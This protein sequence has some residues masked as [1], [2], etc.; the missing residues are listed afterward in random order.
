M[1]RRQLDRL[2]PSGGPTHDTGCIGL[3]FRYKIHVPRRS[4]IGPRVENGYTVRK[5]HDNRKRIVHAAN[6]PLDCEQLRSKAHDPD[7]VPQQ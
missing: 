5:A 6:V 3:P 2:P 7:W 4:D 1:F